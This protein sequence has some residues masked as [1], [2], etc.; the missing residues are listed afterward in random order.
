MRTSS[1]KPLSEAS[2]T[3]LYDIIEASY[4][5]SDFHQRRSIPDHEK[6]CSYVKSRK[7]ICGKTWLS[8]MEIIYHCTALNQI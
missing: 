5:K 6:F 3:R 8:Y 4:D 2:I 1:Q 7:P